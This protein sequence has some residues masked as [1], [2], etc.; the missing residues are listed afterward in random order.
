MLRTVRKRGCR[1]N[2]MLAKG[3]SDKT[4]RIKAENAAAA[5]TDSSC[6][7]RHVHPRVLHFL[8]AAR[9]DLFQRKVPQLR[10]TRR[11]LQR[12]S[13]SD[14]GR[15]GG[16]GPP[17]FGPRKLRDPSA[18]VLMISEVPDSTLLMD[19]RPVFSCQAASGS[20]VLGRLVQH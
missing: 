20:T 16:L 12:S 4:Q 11:A 17:A 5:F 13:M 9:S 10:S 14:P 15:S 18:W 6:S 1:G 2:P 3:T 7:R 8:R 19:Q